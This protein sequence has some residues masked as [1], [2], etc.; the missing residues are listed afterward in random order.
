MATAF[1]DIKS[2]FD[3][4]WHPAILQA[5]AHKSCPPYLI[6]MVHSFLSNRRATL[7][8]A[9]TEH[10]VHLENGCPQGS[11]LSPILWITLMDKVLRITLD[12]PFRLV[13]YADDLTAAC[14][15]RD[16]LIATK[17]AEVV[18]EAVVRWGCRG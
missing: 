8:G 10:T 4:A 7:L 2:A 6:C 12:F 13:G 11:V 14:H 1:L 3:C 5:L 17:R 15:H 18:C 16:P 9:G